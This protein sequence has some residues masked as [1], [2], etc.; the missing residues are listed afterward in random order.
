MVVPFGLVVLSSPG[1][2]RIRAEAR[3]ARR[4]GRSIEFMSIAAVVLAV[5]ANLQQQTEMTGAGWAFMAAAWIAILW[6]TIYS[7]GKILRK[8]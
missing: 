6:A 3:T 8:K 4:R 5:Q 2:V 1:R 7:F